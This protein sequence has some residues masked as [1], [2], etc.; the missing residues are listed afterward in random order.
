[1]VEY[2]ATVEAERIRD[3]LSQTK[4]MLV[5][6]RNEPTFRARPSPYIERVWQD[7]KRVRLAINCPACGRMYF[8]N[9]KGEWYSD[10]PLVI[11]E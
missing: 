5:R 10:R 4:P 11:L 7:E 1:M 9:E 2:S 8:L 3:L 6:C